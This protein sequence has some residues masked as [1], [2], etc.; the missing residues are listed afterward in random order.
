MCIF[1]TLFTITMSS[2]RK[3][4]KRVREGEINLPTRKVLKKAIAKAQLNKLASYSDEYKVASVEIKFIK[5]VNEI[6]RLTSYD[7]DSFFHPFKTC[8]KM[9]SFVTS[10]S[11]CNFNMKAT[12]DSR[13]G[14]TD[15]ENPQTLKLERKA[16]VVCRASVTDSGAPTE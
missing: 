1:I 8:E 5:S 11:P 3:P 10:R 13:L 2:Y 6:G 4:P 15:A 14:A 12:P 9:N 7:F 16:S